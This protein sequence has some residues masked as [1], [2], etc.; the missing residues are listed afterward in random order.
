MLGWQNL[1]FSIHDQAAVCDLDYFFSNSPYKKNVRT[2]AKG[3]DAEMAKLQVPAF[4]I[5]AAPFLSHCT[6]I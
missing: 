1:G 3:L 5:V 2:A 6:L 4:S